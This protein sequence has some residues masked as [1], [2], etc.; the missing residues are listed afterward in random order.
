[1]EVVRAGQEV[2]HLLKIM[3]FLHLAEDFQSILEL[4]GMENCEDWMENGKK[5]LTFLTKEWCLRFMFRM[6][7]L[8]SCHFEYWLM[9]PYESSSLAFVHPFAKLFVPSKHLKASSDGY[10]WMILTIFPSVQTKPEQK[11]CLNSK[12]T[13]SNRLRKFDH[14]HKDLPA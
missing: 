4:Y 14:V 2:V 10:K 7:F 5:G 12:A 11:Q 13:R 6:L 9:A 8:E 3:V 1:M